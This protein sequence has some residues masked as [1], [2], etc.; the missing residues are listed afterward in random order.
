MKPFAVHARRKRSPCLSGT[1]GPK[2]P[3]TKKAHN[4]GASAEAVS[5]LP[6]T[7][8]PEYD[9]LNYVTIN[10][11]RDSIGPLILL[12]LTLNEVPA[13]FELDTGAAVSLH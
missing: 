9:P 4:V 1:K 7:E 5:E 8:S 6:L 12:D 2:P 13:Q 11:V 10:V 3:S